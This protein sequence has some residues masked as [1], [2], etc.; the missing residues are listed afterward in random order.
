MEY[1]HDLR[2]VMERQGEEI[3]SINNIKDSLEK[4]G[5]LQD[6]ITK[7]QDPES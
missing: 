2:T 1:I 3:L 7:D 5:K 6:L 4:D